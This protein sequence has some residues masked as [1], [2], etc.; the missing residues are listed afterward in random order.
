MQL[1]EYRFNF[2]VFFT[3][4]DDKHVT[5]PWEVGRVIQYRKLGEDVIEGSLSGAINCTEV[6]KS[7][8]QEL[9]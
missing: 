4:G 8:N 9:T 7:V 5:I 2:G 3:D 1:E 6:F